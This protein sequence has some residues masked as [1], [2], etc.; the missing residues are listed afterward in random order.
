MDVVSLLRFRVAERILAVLIGGFSIYLGYRLF[1]E[2]PSANNSSG[3]LSLPGDISI[4]ISRVGPGVFFSLF[5]AAIVTVSLYQGLE[6]KAGVASEGAKNVA[7]V[8]VNYAN[9]RVGRETDA[10]K[11]NALR[12]EARRSISELNKFPALLPSDV[13]KTRAFDVMQAVRATK[14][15]LLEPVQGK[16]WGSLPKKRAFL[17]ASS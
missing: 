10:E 6:L 11:L 12:A 7:N 14:L 9:D 4:Y 2:I 15:A 3:K 17:G 16:D 5:G 1:S 8:E 13:P